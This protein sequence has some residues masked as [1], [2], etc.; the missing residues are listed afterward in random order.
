MQRIVWKS[1]SLKKKTYGLG[2]TKLLV[3]GT[4]RAAKKLFIFKIFFVNFF[5]NI[6]LTRF[7]LEL[8]TALSCSI[9]EFYKVKLQSL[10]KKKFL[11]WLKKISAY[12]H[13]DHINEEESTIQFWY[14]SRISS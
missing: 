11:E 4:T 10:T 1:N 2:I 13:Y 5:G 14:V 6:F 12:F 9:H 7:P 3:L 8:P